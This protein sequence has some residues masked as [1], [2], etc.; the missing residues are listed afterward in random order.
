LEQG[1]YRSAGLYF[2]LCGFSV[3]DGTAELAATGKP[4][5]HGLP[6]STDEIDECLALHKQKRQ[7]PI[8]HQPE[9]TIA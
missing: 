1:P 3:K 5:H 6:K 9:K 8:S 7:T 2:G 4:A